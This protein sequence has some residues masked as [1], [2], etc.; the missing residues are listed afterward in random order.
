MKFRPSFLLLALVVAGSVSMVSCTKKY[1][2][3]CV[4]KYSGYPG[5]P[6]S[7][8]NEYDITNSKTEA[9]SKCEKMSVSVDR[10]GVHTQETCILY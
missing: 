2:C 5:M 8:V 1:T 3:R 10:N 6:D 7:V 9:K 4:I